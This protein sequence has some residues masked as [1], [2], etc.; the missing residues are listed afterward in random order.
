MLN[1]EIAMNIYSSQS[2]I[3][4][5]SRQSER[6]GEAADHKANRSA[7]TAPE[8]GGDTV[9]LTRTAGEVQKL[10]S[11][12]AQL[13]EIDH[14]RVASIKAAIDNGSYEVN[15]DKIADKLLN[16]EQTLRHG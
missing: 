10:E 2:G 4:Q 1:R 3:S 9:T 6:L 8:Q 12:L 15:P 14:A 7:P 5:S 16:M 13:P 11:Q